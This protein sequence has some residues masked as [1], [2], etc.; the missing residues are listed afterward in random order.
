MN[1]PKN[2][3]EPDPNGLM[4]ILRIGRGLSIPKDKLY[5]LCH[6]TLLGKHIKTPFCKTIMTKKFS[7]RLL[8]DGD[9]VT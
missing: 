8:R 3:L 7:N 1:A 6:I 2:N 4:N 9:L 5:N